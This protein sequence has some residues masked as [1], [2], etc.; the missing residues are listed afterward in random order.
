MHKLGVIWDTPYWQANCRDV[1]F[2]PLHLFVS[3]FYGTSFT[4]NQQSGS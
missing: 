4:M 3:R 2:I 1:Y